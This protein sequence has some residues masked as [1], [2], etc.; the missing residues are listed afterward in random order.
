MKHS[1]HLTTIALT[2]LGF[3]LVQCTE[4]TGISTSN[5]L[6]NDQLNPSGQFE[7]EIVGDTISPLVL[8]ENSL[9]I[10]LTLDE[11]EDAVLLMVSHNE[12]G[13]QHGFQVYASENEAEIGFSA[14]KLDTNN[15]TESAHEILR[16]AE[17]KLFTFERTEVRSSGFAG[18]MNVED[19][20]TFKIIENFSD[21]STY[22]SVVSTL[23]FD[24]DHIHLYIDNRDLDELSDDQI[25]QMIDSAEHFDT[26]VAPRENLLFGEPSDVDQ[27]DI[28]YVVASREVNE[29]YNSLGSF[30]TGYFYAG[31]T[32]SP[33]INPASNE[34][35]VVF[36]IVPDATGQHGTYVSD[37]IFFENI[38]EGVIAHEYQHC[39]NFNQRYLVNSTTIELPAMN[40]FLSHLAEDLLNNMETTGIENYSRVSSCLA[41]LQNIDI[42][43]GT[44]LTQRGCGYLMTRYFYE[45]VE[46]GHFSHVA[47]GQE[48]VRS[49]LTSSFRGTDNLK[50]ALFGDPNADQE[51]SDW[52]SRFAITLYLSDTDLS[53]GDFYQM[54]GINLR[55]ITNDN[56]GTYLNGPPLMELG[57]NTF[58]GIL[59]GISM[60]FIKIQKED[61]GQSQSLFLNVEDTSTLNAYLIQ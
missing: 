25:S 24:G 59:D 53:D 3:Q 27:N 16:D 54:E 51:F 20:K 10:P 58:T 35:E 14:Q 55:A 26:Q 18:V 33:D 57:T 12:E 37:T 9:T 1:K 6:N 31:D 61:L 46:K 15:D 17:E 28:L 41:N 34:A 8:D 4:L 47:S 48:F 60:A 56:R 50:Y 21:T 32:F 44:S 11:N 36:T 7:S 19:E 40:E 45:Q 43:G 22:N 13:D 52:I 23:L 42:F 5:N 2:L 30:V 49:L 39:V 29:Y 38:F